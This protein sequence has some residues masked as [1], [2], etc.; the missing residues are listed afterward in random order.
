MTDDEQAA[1]SY[2]Y[3]SPHRYDLVAL[4]SGNYA[5]FRHGHSFELWIG[6]L[7]ELP[8]AIPTLPAGLSLPPRSPTSKAARTAQLLADLDLDNL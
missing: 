3:S 7:A 4:P 1:R 2:R 5:I 8:A 6:P